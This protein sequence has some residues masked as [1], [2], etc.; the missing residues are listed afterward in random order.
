MRFFREQTTG[1]SVIMGRKTFDSLGRRP[2]VGRYNVVISHHFDLFP[3]TPECVLGIGIEDGLLRASLAPKEFKETFVI[4]GA[5]MYKQF[6]RYVDRYLITLVE[7]EVKDGDTFFDQNFLG[8]PDEWE[9]D[10]ICSVPAGPKD[11]AA[12]SVFEV[13]STRCSLYRGERADAIARAKR[14]SMSSGAPKKK[15]S[16]RRAAFSTS[17]TLSML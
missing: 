5:S 13:T 10:Q 4:G 12:F 14:V 7:K 11:E 16:Q 3:E 15:R 6:S 17:Q 2:L 1:N 8:N 9:I